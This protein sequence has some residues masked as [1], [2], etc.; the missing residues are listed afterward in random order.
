V[1]NNKTKKRRNNP[2]LSSSKITSVIGRTTITRRIRDSKSPNKT[3]MIIIDHPQH[4]NEVM[5]ITKAEVNLE[6]E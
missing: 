3:T 2:N 1:A 5:Q 6:V 4:L